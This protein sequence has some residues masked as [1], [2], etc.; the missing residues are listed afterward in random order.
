MAN[1]WIDTWLYPAKTKKTEEKS[2]FSS[3]WNIFTNMF[4]WDKKKE[5]VEK[6]DNN[7]ETNNIV[8]WNN[9]DIGVNNNMILNNNN[10]T[11][12]INGINGENNKKWIINNNTKY[13]QIKYNEET[14]IYDEWSIGGW[15]MPVTNFKN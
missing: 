14:N 5:N 3:I 2:I 12:G 11:N 7:I 13:S 1:D 9:I 6:F 10:G 15:T 4:S 8:T